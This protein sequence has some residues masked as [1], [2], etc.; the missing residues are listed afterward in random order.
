MTGRGAD[1]ENP[2]REDAGS[3]HHDD[4]AALT[5]RRR[6]AVLSI[7]APVVAGVLTRLCCCAGGSGLPASSA[8]RPL[9]HH[10]RQASPTIEGNPPGRAPRSPRPGTVTATHDDLPVLTSPR[11]P[12]RNLTAIRPVAAGGSSRCPGHPDRRGFGCLS[13]SPLDLAPVTARRPCVPG[14]VWPSLAGRLHGDHEPVAYRVGSAL[15]LA[16]HCFEQ[17]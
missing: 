16:A 6:V 12:G 15:K 11:S 17:K 7:F 4:A 13:W 3:G 14:A 2:P 1:S 5:P 9:P 10:L 8:G